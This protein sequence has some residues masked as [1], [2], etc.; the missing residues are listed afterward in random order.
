[1]SRES[2]PV[3]VDVG[4][5]SSGTVGVVRVQWESGG[6]G[7]WA[8]KSSIERFCD[9]AKQP[10]VFCPPTCQ[11]RSTRAV[12]ISFTRIRVTHKHDNNV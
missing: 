1:M 11:T 7:G 3:F 8:E 9:G 10:T 4:R 5:A 12:K 6:G 2:I